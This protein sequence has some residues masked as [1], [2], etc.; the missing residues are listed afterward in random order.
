MVAHVKPQTKGLEFRIGF[1]VQGGRDE[2]L[3]ERLLGAV[4]VQ[5]LDLDAPAGLTTIDEG[6]VRLNPST[7]ARSRLFWDRD[8][9]RDVAWHPERPVVVTSSWDGDVALWSRREVGDADVVGDLRPTAMPG[10]VPS[11]G[12]P[13]RGGGG[14]R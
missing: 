3:P 2:E 1:T 8:V 9:V 14:R 13:R 10:E 4:H 12:S 7:P 5:D 11:A 6:G